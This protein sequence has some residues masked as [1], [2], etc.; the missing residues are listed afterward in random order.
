MYTCTGINSKYD[1]HERAYVDDDHDNLNDGYYLIYP[2]FAQRAP[3]ILA[4]SQYVYIFLGQT[5]GCT[6]SPVVQIQDDWL[7]FNCQ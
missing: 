4:G 2:W 3:L 5:Q 1:D 7:K 6:V